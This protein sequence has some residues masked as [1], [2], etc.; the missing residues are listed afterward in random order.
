MILPIN[1]PY[2]TLENAG[3]KGT[4]L[5]KLSR[6]G[7]PIPDGF[8]ITTDAYHNFIA[9]NDLMGK[10]LDRV[11]T[12][13]SRN[14]SALE[15]AA[16]EIRS[17]FTNATIPLYLTSQ[18]LDAYK[19]LGGTPVAVRSSA[20]A[21]DLSDLSFA[22]QQDTFLNVIGQESLLT[23][24]VDC[25]SS[26]WTARAIGYRARN[27][28]SHDEVSIAVLIQK[29]VPAEVSGI[30]FN[31]NPLTG[32][33]S[34][35][36]IDA[37]F[38]LGEAL[39]GGHVEPD[40]YVVDIVKQ[41]ILTKKI[42]TKEITILGKPGGGVQRTKSASAQVQALSDEHILK[43]ARLGDRIEAIY[44]FPQDIEWAWADG[45][46]QLLQARPITSLYPVPESMGSD[47]LRVMLS[48]ATIQGIL[49][50]ITPLGQDAI[51]LIF[52]G[53]ASLFDVQVTHET[54]GLIKISGQRLWVD[55][56]AG[57]HHP[58]GARAIPRFFSVVDPTTVPVFVKLK[59]EPNL[60]MGKGR[61]HLSTIRKL[62]FFALP[63]IRNILRITRS[64]EG[65]AE[66]IQQNSQE[67]IAEL[68][69]K[70]ELSQ[71]DR[72]TLTH[73]VRVFRELYDAFPYAVPNIFSGA[74]AGLIPFFLLNRLA[75]HLTGSTDLAL[76]ITRSLPHNVTLE[77][78]LLLWETACAIRSDV[79]AYQHFQS[80]SA[81][82]LSAEYLEGKLPESA[83]KVIARFLGKYGMRGIGEIDIG[84]PRWRED[85]QE[86]MQTIQSYLQIKDCSQ[87]PDAI[88]KR[89]EKAAEAA[90]LELEAAAQKTF[91]GKL[92][93]RIIRGT[94]RLVRNLAGLRESPKFHI[95]QMMGIIRQG[96]LECG[97]DL[98][99]KEIFA[100][101]DDLFFLYLTELDALARGEQRNWKAII[102][103]RREIYAREMFRAR[104]PHLL[105]SDGRVFYAG[106]T[107][108]DGV[109]SDL[110][111]HP[112]SP[113]AVEGVVRV[114]LDPHDAQL[115]PG[116]I[117]VCPATDPAWTPLFLA[118]SGL[119]METGGMMTH[120][121]IVAREYGIPAVVGVDRATTLLCTGQRIRLDGSTGEIF[122]GN[123]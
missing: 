64:P 45:E 19:M 60:G 82:Q 41:E 13:P 87:T 70:S 110:Q 27:G 1:S 112:V 52:A 75:N 12:I 58:L 40:H 31:A 122:F 42:G 91:A 80:S 2:A 100:Q 119:I 11:S 74:G 51:R 69:V 55:I 57:L 117:L 23:A 114:V 59:D 116:E 81:E 88:F 33:R 108:T 9:E 94:A 26:L 36:V 48:F 10:I 73:W 62:A 109:K 92:K 105:L 15:D 67:K 66:Q 50:P 32:L 8:I 103:D 93:S 6:A 24:V 95:I 20:T 111:G 120:G 29:M 53:G 56:T 84:R 61:I 22:G 35:T 118:A 38:G 7:L 89:G 46:F 63:M 85:P 86:I 98:V 83:Q 102:A 76:T 47:P 115:T 17:W 44:G 104:I 18:V 3:G 14:P 106:I 28:I 4:N 79:E 97:K 123:N 21:E 30:M 77:M 99:S 90:I 65:K 49:E 54:L 72:S 16:R 37:A 107:S 96:F 121:A 113:G 78:D 43:L 68:R 25:W 101:V 5:S 34:E 39:V 71:G